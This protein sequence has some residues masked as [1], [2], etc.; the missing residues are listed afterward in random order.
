[1]GYL[2]LKDSAERMWFNES[3]EEEARLRSQ[4]APALRTVEEQNAIDTFNDT[5]QYKDGQYSCGLLWKSQELRD[6][7]PDDFYEALRIFLYHERTM[8]ANEHLR[9]Q[10]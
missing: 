2:Q 5:L 7:L 9:L 1:M 4:L 3:L 8:A 6:K 10:Y